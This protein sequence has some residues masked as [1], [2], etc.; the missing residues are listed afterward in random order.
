MVKGKV[1]LKVAALYLATIL[2]FSFF[3]WGVTSVDA[4]PPKT[5]VVAIDAGHGGID[6]GAYGKKTKIAESEINLELAVEL[7][8]QLNSLGIST[9]LTRDGDY[10]LYGDTSAGFKRRDMVKRK[11]IIE[12]SSPD[13]VI[14]LHCNYSPSG[15]PRGAEVYYNAGSDVGKAFAENLQRSILE[16]NNVEKCRLDTVKLFMTHDIAA[17]SVIVEC[18]FLSNFEDEKMLCDKNFHLKF[19]KQI[20]SATIETLSKNVGLIAI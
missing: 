2:T 12:N 9:V 8:R 1:F 10:G 14:S 15:K 6:K 17:P 20:C 16:L 3:V 4:S 18:G 13:L 19:C 5:F 11:E 7:S